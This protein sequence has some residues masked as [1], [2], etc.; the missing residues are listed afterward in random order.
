MYLYSLDPDILF[1]NDITIHDSKRTDARKH[2]TLQDFCPKASPV[3]QADMRRFQHRLA[4]ITPESAKGGR[5]L[6][7]GVSGIVDMVL[8]DLSVVFPG[9]FRDL[10]RLW[11]EAGQTHIVAELLNG[12]DLFQ[13]Q[14]VDGL[15][16]V[17]GIQVNPLQDA[18]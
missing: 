14:L 4:M 6:V 18:Y 8:P 1:G 15:S 5:G 9:L 12:I 16:V 13:R 17:T 10:R 2:Q 11:R 3:D 7:R